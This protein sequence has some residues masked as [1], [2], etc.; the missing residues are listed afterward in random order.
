MDFQLK[1]FLKQ[2]KPAGPNSGKVLKD[3]GCVDETMILPPEVKGRFIGR[4][5]NQIKRLAHVT[6]TQI[7]IVSRNQ[8]DHIQFSGTEAAV[9]A[10]VKDTTTLIAE[11]FDRREHSRQARMHRFQQADDANSSEDI[12]RT[13]G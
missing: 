6:Q 2:G 9:S 10:A 8:V 11:L 5:G 13:S 7:S 3:T 1:A 4:F 12:A